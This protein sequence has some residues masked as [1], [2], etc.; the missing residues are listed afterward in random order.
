MVARS[1]LHQDRVNQNELKLSSVHVWWH[2]KNNRVH[3]RVLGRE[4]DEL[5]GHQKKAGAHIRLGAFLFA[6]QSIH[7]TVG[8]LVA[9]VVMGCFSS[10]WPHRTKSK[11]CYLCRDTGM[12]KKNEERGLV[13]WSV[14]HTMPCC[15]LLWSKLLHCLL[16]GSQTKE[17]EGKKPCRSQTEWSLLLWMEMEKQLHH[18]KRC[19]CFHPARWAHTLSLSHLRTLAV[20]TKLSDFLLSSSVRPPL[21]GFALLLAHFICCIFR[22][23]LPV[24]LYLSFSH[25]IVFL[26]PH[27]PLILSLSA[28]C[29]LTVL[30]AAHQLI[31]CSRLEGLVLP[32]SWAF[33]PCDL[34]ITHW[35]HPIKHGLLRCFYFFIVNDLYWH[36]ELSD[37]IFPDFVV[38]IFR[39]Q[40]FPSNHTE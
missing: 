17:G 25:F 5:V 26:S 29:S 15:V 28:A 35:S 16:P 9:S 38:Y 39:Q 13:L 2:E 27:P 32:S 20:C 34:A 31:W 12:A 30:S 36:I 10:H 22:V 8:L 1:K 11:S 24:F 18:E 33:K 19:C 37:S 14:S 21:P 23:T 6:A 7:R 40:S 4:R 3:R